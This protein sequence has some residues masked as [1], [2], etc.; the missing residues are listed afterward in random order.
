MLLG[1]ALAAAL[2][3]TVAVDAAEFSNAAYTVPCLAGHIP[4]SRDLYERLWQDQLRWSAQ[5]DE[6]LGRWKAVVARATAAAPPAS[7]APLLANFLSFY[8]SVR[9]RMAIV[10]AVAGAGSTRHVARAARRV[11]SS[12]DARIL[13]EVLEHF[14]RRLR[15]W[16]QSTGRAVVA[17]HIAQVK[18]GLT[19]DH[20]A[21][22]SSV[23]A[24]IGA[25]LPAARVFVHAVPGPAA[26][27]DESAATVVEQHFFV[28]IV[29]R[30][31]ARETVWKAMHELTHA[32]YDAAPADTHAELMRQFVEAPEP[33]AA[34]FYAY[35]NETLATAVQYIVLERDGE[36]IGGEDGGYRHPFIPRLARALLPTVRTA[37]ASGGSITQGIVPAY[38]TAGRAS[39]GDAASQPTFT[40]ASA[41]LIGADQHRPAIAAFRQAFNVWSSTNTMQEWRAFAELSAVFFVTHAE[42][43]RDGPQVPD[44]ELAVRHRAFAYTTRHHAKSRI[45]VLA[46]RDPSAVSDL[47]TQ[48]SALPTFPAD[49]V[50]LVID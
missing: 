20:R 1:L 47:V 38:L 15:P 23:S 49:G 45:L 19:T 33:S 8:P 7:P 25:R 5:D 32:Y 37:L 12:D 4:C 27:G 14:E 48:L 28:E 31:T 46:G 9:A 35:F 40:L 16:W 3:L 2:P 30:D 39:L 10:S 22:S 6:Q 21:I 43:L 11:V 34:A 42:L 17:G 44:V 29:S 13:Q 41:A 18:E 36:S 50:F 26:A 24:F